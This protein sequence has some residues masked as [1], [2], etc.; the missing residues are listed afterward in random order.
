VHGLHQK[1][2][3]LQICS[4]SVSLVLFV[5]TIVESLKS[6]FLPLYRMEIAFSTIVI[7]DVTHRLA[8]WDTAGQEDFD[9]LRLL[10]YPNVR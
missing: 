9:R 8:I 4:D 2:F 3:P 7:N 6:Y 5:L 10:S 1:M